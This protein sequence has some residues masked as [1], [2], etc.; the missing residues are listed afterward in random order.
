ML[1]RCR[2]R[3][4]VDGAEGATQWPFLAALLAEH[5]VGGGDLTRVF[6]VRIYNAFS[7]KTTSLR[8]AALQRQLE[9]GFS[10]KPR[11]P[12]SLLLWE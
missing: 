9:L 10:G 5:G 3:P 2:G 6:F 12:P 8:V 1:L 11:L 4:A 7:L